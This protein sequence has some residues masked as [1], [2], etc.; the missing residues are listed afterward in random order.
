MNTPE[1]D[2]FPDADVRASKPEG[3][4]LDEWRLRLALAACYRVFEHRGWAEEIFN[5]ITVRVPGPQR[6]YLINPFGL[7][8][9]EVT[10]ANLVKVDIAGRTVGDNPHPVN[11]AGFIIHSAIHGARDDT[12]CIMHTHHTPGLAVACKAD[13][14]RL[15]NFYAGFLYGRVAYHDFEGVT[16]HEDEQQRLVASLGD[17]NVLILR[18]HGLLTTG[19]DIATAFYWLYVLQRACEVQLAA[20][21]MSGPTLQ[22]SREACEVSARDVQ[23]SDPQRALFPKVFAAA[24]RR[25]GVTLQQLL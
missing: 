4:A 16:V 19:P 10:A 2:L 13:G 22:L 15:N 8:Y 9:G 6:H 17:K 25:A 3:M 23:E 5:H 12:H 21:S 24:V 11:R 1:P 7:I 14:L 18:Q 20:D